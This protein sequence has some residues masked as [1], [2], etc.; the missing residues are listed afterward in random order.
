MYT[1]VGLIIPSSRKTLAADLEGNFDEVNFSSISPEPFW[2][3]AKKFVPVTNLR[4]LR[5]TF[6]FSVYFPSTEKLA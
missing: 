1:L 2:I 5:P 3:I 4:K 6:F